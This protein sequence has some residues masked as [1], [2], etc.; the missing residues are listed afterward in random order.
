VTINIDIIYN[1]SFIIDLVV[2]ISL[3]VTSIAYID[4]LINIYFKEVIV[5]IIF[6]IIMFFSIFVLIVVIIIPIIITVTG[7]M[8]NTY[9]RLSQYVLNIYTDML[10]LVMSLW[11]IASALND[12]MALT[13]SLAKSSTSTLSMDILFSFTSIG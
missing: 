10:D 1:V 6:D 7:I 5:I 11:V 8:T 13:V 12:V 3:I 9:F 2:T 4:I